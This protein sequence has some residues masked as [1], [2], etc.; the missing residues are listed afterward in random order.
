MPCGLSERLG[1]GPCGWALSPLD[2]PGIGWDTGESSGQLMSLGL[3]CSL[4]RALWAPR[5]RTEMLAEVRV[6]ALLSCFLLLLVAE[7]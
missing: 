1:W 5:L 4:G 7:A 6:L 3:W 2:G